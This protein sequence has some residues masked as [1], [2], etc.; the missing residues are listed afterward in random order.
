[1]GRGGGGANHAFRLDSLARSQGR[2]ASKARRPDDGGCAEGEITHSLIC[3]EQAA[4]KCLSCFSSYWND[5][6][7]LPCA[8]FVV[9]LLVILAWL[10]QMEHGCLAAVYVGSLSFQWL[11]FFARSQRGGVRQTCN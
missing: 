4:P 3:C 2:E 9:R 5:F 10:L 8:W 7:Q 11:H 1:M 6:L